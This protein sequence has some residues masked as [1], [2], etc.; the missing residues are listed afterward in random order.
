MLL[1]VGRKGIATRFLLVLVVA[2][3]LTTASIATASAAAEAA[4]SSESDVSI[5]VLAPSGDLSTHDCTAS[6]VASR[7]GDVIVTAAHCVSGTGAGMV[8]AP[9]YRDGVAP[10]GTWDVIAAYVAPGW[11]HDLDP[12]DDVAFLVVTPSPTN[13]RR[14]PVQ[15]VVGGFAL[16]TA[17][18]AG[19]AVQVTGY[20]S[21][22]VDP[23]T[24]DAT[25]STIGGFPR[26]D[27]D[28]F[29][30]GTSGGPWIATG[31]VRPATIAAVIGGPNQGGC[32][33][34]TSYSSPFTPATA[35]LLRRAGRGG[36]ADVLPAATS[37][38][39]ST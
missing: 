19:T 7:A 1:R 9:G 4:S 18:R 16:G 30:G 21:D 33:A 35:A 3:L 23:V 34:T 27:C 12:A 5:G 36:P 31:P 38:G 29:A 26:F 22:S 15:N 10:Y 17:P 20:V 24:C 25:T 2:M 6:V 28:G 8:F 14:Q 13:L 39:C 32:A 11:L 37:D